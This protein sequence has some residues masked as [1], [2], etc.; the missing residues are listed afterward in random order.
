MFKSLFKKEEPVEE[1]SLPLVKDYPKT[2]YSVY[3]EILDVDGGKEIRFMSYKKGLIDTVRVNKDP[4]E[5][6]RV[7]KNKMSKYKEA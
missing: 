7:I 5:L 6:A 3:W 1:V 2:K 4:A